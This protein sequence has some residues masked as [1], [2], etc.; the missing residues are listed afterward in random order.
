M[1]AAALLLAFGACS[2]GLDVSRNEVSSEGVVRVAFGATSPA[3]RAAG[4]EVSVAA[5]KATA[6]EKAVTSLYA[7]IFKDVSEA[8]STSVAIS[9]SAAADN[10]TYFKVIE[11]LS[12]DLNKDNSTFAEGT[13]YKFNLGAGN[14]QFCFIANPGAALLTKIKGVGTVADFKALV[15][16]EEPAAKP[17]LMTSDYIGGTVTSEGLDLTEVGGAENTVILTRAMARIDIVNKASGVTI[18]SI[19]LKNRANKSTLETSTSNTG[20]EDKTYDASTVVTGG[21]APYCGTLP[22]VGDAVADGDGRYPEYD[23]V[24]YSYEQLNTTENLPSIVITYTYSISGVDKTFT[25]EI[26]FETVDGEKIVLKRNWLYTVNVVN[27]KGKV[28]FTLTVKDWEEGT[29]FVKDG[30]ALREGF[31]SD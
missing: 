22:F 18:S 23:K 15:V 27:S 17:M 5:D 4:G 3:T 10:D 19:V 24:I 11:L 31:I 20:L 8:N 25:K 29:T 16:D 13:D 2:Q 28:N 14:Y 7:V 1:T 9:K 21:D 6:A 26:P 30:N 12:D